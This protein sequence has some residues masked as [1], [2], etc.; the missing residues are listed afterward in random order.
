MHFPTKVYIAA[1]LLLIGGGFGVIFGLIQVVT[2]TISWLTGILPGSD[3]L[4]TWGAGA[5]GNG[6]IDLLIG[7]VEVV[8][9]FGLF[10]RQSWA[11]LLAIVATVVAALGPLI[12][13]FSGHFLSIFGLIVPAVILWILVSPDVRRAFGHAAA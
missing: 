7:G 11:W 4:S 6:L 2:G 12:S 9:A 3:S 13:L 1:I 5:V 8:A 10:L